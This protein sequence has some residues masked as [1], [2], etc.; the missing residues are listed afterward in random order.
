[1]TPSEVLSRYW[2][3]DSFRPVQEDIIRSFLSGR[4]TIGLMPTGGG[5]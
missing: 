2:G 3:Y 1:M 4:D 5:K